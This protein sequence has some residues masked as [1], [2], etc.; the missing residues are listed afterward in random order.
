MQRRTA[1]LLLAL[2]GCLWGLGFP[3][4]KVA[5]LELNVNHM[6]L[7]RLAI[8]TV[9]LLPFL[10]FHTPKVA[11]RD[12]S[13]FVLTSLIG[14]PG[15][16]IVQFWGLSKTT[17]SHAA[18]MVGTLPM[19][20]ALGVVIFTHERLSKVAWFAVLG[21]AVGASM[22][23]LSAHRSSGG[24]GPTLIGDVAVLI[25]MFAAVGWIMACKSLLRR[26]PPLFVTGLIFLM[27]TSMMAVW[28]LLLNG[29][30]P[31]HLA[32]RTWWALVAQGLLSTTAATIFW[33]WGL[34][35]VPAAEAGVF[36]NFEPLVG[37]ILSVVFLG[38]R[39]GA[40]AIVGG[41]MILGSAVYLTKSG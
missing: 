41:I 13:I 37:T 30:P 31:L 28:I 27:G 10:F 3:L 39:L 15:V 6:V 4:G 36:T 38:D 14:V 23:V 12:W 2:S 40:L 8:A 5:L 21:S 11:R 33:N 18:L 34:A 9:G 1:L 24:Q 25:S 32:T 20:L 29:L 7:Y 19:L 17:A 26:Y 22:I 35:H 16:Y